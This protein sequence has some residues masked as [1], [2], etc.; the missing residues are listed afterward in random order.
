MHSL[1][2]YYF[3]LENKNPTSCRPYLP[4]SELNNMD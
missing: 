3:N 1:G 2:I 4:P